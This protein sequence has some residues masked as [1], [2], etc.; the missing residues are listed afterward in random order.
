MKFSQGGSKASE[1]MRRVMNQLKAGTRVG[2]AADP[3]DI[4]EEQ[5]AGVQ[6]NIGP[7]FLIASSDAGITCV[8]VMP[9]SFSIGAEKNL[10]TIQSE[11]SMTPNA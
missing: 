1:R 2:S 3:V 7:L 6:A 8:V 9:R 10:I 11:S 5:A 4:D